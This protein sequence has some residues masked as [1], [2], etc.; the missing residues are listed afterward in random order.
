[1]DKKTL[2]SLLGLATGVVLSGAVY[3]QSL[4][5]IWQQAQARDPSYIA[6]GR[7]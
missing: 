3:G 2:R 5:E 6:A 4:T 7:E 1:M